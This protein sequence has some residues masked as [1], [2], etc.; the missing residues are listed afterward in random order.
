MFPL[1][2]QRRRALR[3]SRFAEVARLL[4]RRSSYILRAVV[5]TY[6]MVLQS[7]RSE[8]EHKRPRM[9]KEEVSYVTF[10]GILERANYEEYRGAPDE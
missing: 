3:L 4:T 10:F 6:D 1:R 5:L 7:V 9:T 8:T 2:R